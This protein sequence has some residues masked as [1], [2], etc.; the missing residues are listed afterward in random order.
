[1]PTSFPIDYAGEGATDAIL[2]RR[3]IEEVGGL[4]GRDHVTGRRAHG[5]QWLDMTL[6]GLA[7]AA[8]HG[9][10]VLVLR[11]LDDAGCAVALLRKLVPQPLPS[12]C[13]R[14]VVREIEAWMLADAAGI[15]KA[16]GLKAQQVPANPEALVNPKAALAAL[17][18]LSPRRETRRLLTGSRQEFQG[19]VGA[20]ISEGW[21]PSRSRTNA[22]SR[23]CP[24]AWCRSD[25]RWRVG[26]PCQAVTADRLTW[27]VLLTAPMVSSVM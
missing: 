17:G 26:P 19:W 24:I 2:A 8:R 5:K 23:S 11:D 25:D 16:L 15:A 14:I 1:M 21:S 7:I 12:F 6:P 9:R 18:R 27:G 3:L 13:V 22:P 4:P 20:F 10:R